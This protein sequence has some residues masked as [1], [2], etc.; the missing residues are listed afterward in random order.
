MTIY[1]I[2]MPLR[3]DMLLYPGT[4]APVVKEYRHMAA[5]DSSNNSRFSMGCHAGTHIDAPRHYVDSSHSIEGVPTV[6]LVGPARVFDLDVT[7]SISADD[8][9]SRD[10]DGV[11][12]ALL[13]TP[14]SERLS[15]P[16]F[17]PSFIYVDGSAAEFLVE[18]GVILVGVDYL[19]VDQYRSPTHPAHHTLLGSGSS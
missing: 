9:A 8:L 15:D 13:R 6:T 16:T 7:E 19:S 18:K 4:D 1:D 12:R 3:S 11:T 2:S 5:G 10:W 17:N 14:N